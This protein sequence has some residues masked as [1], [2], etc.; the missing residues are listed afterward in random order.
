M[1]TLTQRSFSSG[2]VSSALYGRVD[3]VK[4]ATGLKTC[5]NCFVMRHGG[6]ASRPG[7]TYVGSVKDHSKTTRLIPF[8]HNIDDTCII[9]FGHL[10]VRFIKNGGYVLD[11]SSIYEVAT[12]YQESELFDVKYVQS[13]DV[14]TLVHPSH[15]PKKLSRFGV[16]NWTLTNYTFAPVAQSP[17]NLSV[18][19]GV[20]GSRTYE[21]KVTAISSELR[22]ESLPSASAS[23]SSAGVPTSASPHTIS[24]T[25]VA[26]ATEYNVYRAVNGVYGFLGIAATN[27]F[28]DVGVNPDTTDTPPEE[29]NPFSGANN[30]PSTA[31]YVQQRLV[32][33]NTSN[34]PD[35][36]EA[37]RTGKY[38]NFT[39]SNPVQDD[40]SVSFGMAGVNKIEHVLN[41]G[42]IIILTNSGEFIVKGDANGMLTPSQIN[43]DQM[44]YH[45]SSSLQPIIAGGTVL[46]VQSG[47]SI[48]RDL[49]F[50]Y[51]V[52]GLTASELSIYSSHLV[53]GYKIND[54]AFQKLP[55][56]ILWIVRNDGVLLSLT[57]VRDQQ[58]A[59]W[60]RHDFKG[61]I[62]ESVSTVRE[63]LEDAVY[64]IIRRTINGQTVRYVE[65]MA[66]R[67]LASN[68]DD[69][70]DFIG[71]D[72][73]L[74]YDGRNSDTNHTMAVT[75]GSSWSHEESLTLTSSSSKFVSTDVGNEVHI[76]DSEKNLIRLSITEYTSPTVV[77]V[78]PNKTV[79]ESMRNTA[80]SSWAFAVDFASGL[81]H[82]QG[83][84]V[85]VF[86]DRFVAANPNNSAYNAVQ[87]DSNG[88]I[89]LDTCYSVIH[90]GLPITCD[91]ETLD[92][93]VFQSETMANKKKNVDSVTM[94]VESTRGV[95]AGGSEPASDDS[96]D[97][98]F[99]H[100]PRSNENYD[101][102]PKLKTEAIKVSIRP[103]WSKGGRVFIRQTDP[104]PLSLLS[105]AVT[106]LIPVR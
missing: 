77:T 25:A 37:S 21:Y 94:M 70:I 40:D 28:K 61:G 24:W 80:V 59:G 67:R 100:A 105:I 39:R 35:T 85:S 73:T 97:G 12:P 16:N 15:E 99:E 69:I 5:R 88:A 9:E 66:Q 44:S 30:Y 51:Q 95:W 101:S 81:G 18:A 38:T 34:K 47:D 43:L 87:V 56:S 49:I 91:I 23:V 19:K 104:V 41:L 64:M 33:A 48:V 82:L 11:G 26:G 7:T 36:V 45:G 72:S 42:G 13:A 50:D 6:V 63:G 31:S 53:D 86:A 93:D 75:G 54:W 92:I 10:Y 32:F 78:R 3:T 20:N 71:M 55:Q 14:L 90:V 98:M 106:G 62:V 27:S 57:Y 83:E 65:R 79:P 46:Y 103:E 96:L 60:A 52:E 8:Q 76:T 84:K 22:E 4:Y 2:E 89:Q 29:R 102:P 58:I 74:T 68:V 1:T 17:T